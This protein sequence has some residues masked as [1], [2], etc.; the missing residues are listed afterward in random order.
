[1]NWFLS[2][3]MNFSRVRFLGLSFSLL[4]IV[5]ALFGLFSRGLNLGI[6]FTGGFIT[7]FST[8]QPVSQENMQRLLEKQIGEKFLLTASEEKTNWTVRQP[9]DANTSISKNWLAELSEEAELTRDQIQVSALDSDYIGTQIGA[10]LINQ[11]GL[12]MMAALIIIMLYL[13]ARFEW[14]FALGAILAL[15]HDV[16]IILG[17]FAW[18][19][20]EFNLTVLASLLAIIG[21]S[22]ND[23]I[24]VADRVRELM[25][26]NKNNSLSDLINSAIKST[27]TRTLIT[28]GTTIATIS[29]VWWLA[30]KPLEGFSV[31]L[32]SG[33]L[34]GTLS[35]ICISATFPQ[36]VGLN[37]DCYRLDPEN[38][39]EKTINY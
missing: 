16:I 17:L 33:I 27:L 4:L 37:I 25:R 15:F 20:L 24:I 7:E 1:M 21:Y 31:A 39:E 6:D 28:S 26:F 10:E 8:S 36:V 32:F 23:S 38:D 19:Q 34:V 5:L 11:G 30:G 13:S 14:R 9:D 18:S 3:P 22:L 29:A 12:A 35:S 2:L